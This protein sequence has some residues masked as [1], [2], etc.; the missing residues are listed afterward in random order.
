M[1]GYALLILLVGLTSVV[2]TSI[3]R[4]YNLTSIMTGILA[5]IFD[6]VVVICVLPMSYFGEKGH[7]PRWLGI[8]AVVHALGALLFAFPQFV[9]GPYLSQ[10]FESNI[11]LCHSEV[12]FSQDCN[13]IST[14]WVSGC[15]NVA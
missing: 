8:G 4:R 3:E 5:S 9:G 7:K 1:I 15:K 2:I 14:H 13:K 11:D 12:D 6:I 10:V